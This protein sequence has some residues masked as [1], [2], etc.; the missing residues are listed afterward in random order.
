MFLNEW[1]AYGKALRAHCD[2]NLGGNKHT[3]WSDEIENVLLLLH[4]LPPPKKRG[5]KKKN[6]KTFDDFIDKLIVYHVVSNEKKMF[7]K[8]ELK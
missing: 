7:K 3:K 1:P 5:R 8:N 2:A 6:M 4:A